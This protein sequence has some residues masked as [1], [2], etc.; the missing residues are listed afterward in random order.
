LLDG[1]LHH[2]RHC[3]RRKPPRKVALAQ[4]PCDALVGV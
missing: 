1:L 4:S 2:A 3:Q